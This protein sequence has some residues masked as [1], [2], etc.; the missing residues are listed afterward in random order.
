M[1]IIVL[2][3]DGIPRESGPQAALDITA[4]FIEHRT[5]WSN[6]QCTWDGERLLLRA[7]SDSDRDGRAL[8]DEFSDCLC[9]YVE[10]LDDGELRIESV[11]P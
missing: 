6:V 2:S 5:W 11:T 10:T 9:A 7:E 3:C 1:A 8:M 4:E